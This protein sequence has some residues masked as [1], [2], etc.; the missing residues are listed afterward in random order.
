LT[1]SLYSLKGL[2]GDF[3]FIRVIINEIEKEYFESLI[4]IK[5]AFSQF[6]PKMKWAGEIIPGHI[7][8][9]G[10]INIGHRSGLLFSG[11]VDSLSSLIMHKEEHPELFTVFGADIFLNEALKIKEVKEDI[12]TTGK[13]FDLRSNF[14]KSNLRSFINEKYLNYFYSDSISSWWGDIQHG[15]GLTGLIAPLSYKKDLSIIYIASTYTEK[16][17]LPRGS[18]PEIDNK[19]R[20]AGTSIVHDG[21]EFDRQ[22][23]TGIITGQQ[24]PIKIR[25]CYIPGA[26]YNCCNCEKCFRTI[27]NILIAGKD[28]DLFGFKTDESLFKKI[29][30]QF[31]N[32]ILRIENINLYYWSSIKDCFC[33]KEKISLINMELPGFFIDWMQH[34][35]FAKNMKQYFKKRK[36]IIAIKKTISR[37]PFWGFYSVLRKI[38]LVRS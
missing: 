19:I 34:Y 8:I 27:M 20:W 22:E 23:K 35:D 5:K 33:S 29:I 17:K 7:K 30:Y 24:L 3:F 25:A 13:T 1:I 26:H 6:F 31:E 4:E 10:K 38:S 15:L 37:Q 21:F 2:Q 36:V 12:N 9:P 16:Y 28:P 32:N 18:M 11:G 14:I